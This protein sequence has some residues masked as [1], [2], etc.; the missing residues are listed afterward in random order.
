MEAESIW[1]G[2]PPQDECS[3]IPISPEPP[4]A[5]PRQWWILCPNKDGAKE[6]LR[7]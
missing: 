6:V 7:I 2:N 5:Q 3:P 4:V 1:V